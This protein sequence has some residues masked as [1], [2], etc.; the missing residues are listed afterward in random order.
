MSLCLEFA[1]KYYKENNILKK[2][3]ATMAKMLKFLS[4]GDEYTNICY[5]LLSSFMYL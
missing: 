2:D 1:L 5:I 3:E 4:L